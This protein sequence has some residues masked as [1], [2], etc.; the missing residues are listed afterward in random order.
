MKDDPDATLL[1]TIT[2]LR[3][4]NAYLSMCYRQVR[5]ELDDALLENDGLRRQVTDLRGRATILGI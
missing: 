1:A 3:D 4:E 2:E 5:A